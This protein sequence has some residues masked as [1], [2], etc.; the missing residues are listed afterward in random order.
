MEQNKQVT[1]AFHRL[2]GMDQVTL[3]TSAELCRLR[4]LDPKLWAALSCPASGLEFDARTLELLD[5]DKDDRIRIPEVLEAMDWVCERL[6]D[7]AEITQ[8][9]EALP[10]SSIR[11]DTDKGRRLAVTA[12][13]ALKNLGR[14]GEESIRY[15]DVALAAA[16]AN[17]LLF[18]GDG[19]FPAH[20]E[21]DEPK[22]SFITAALS[23]AGGQNDASGIPGIDAATIDAFLA[24]LKAEKDWRKALCEAPHAL[25]ADTPAAW[26]LR[27]ELKDKI[28]DYFLRCRLASFAPQSTASLNAEDQLVSP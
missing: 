27:Q 10:L 1:W 22:R 14:E 17:A 6:T 11:V 5:N 23:V 4:E 3:M 25:G 20:D 13:T 28:D 21:L 15:E 7:P 9:A 18:N 24:A 8:R 2:G 16:S 12:A 19:I 26:A